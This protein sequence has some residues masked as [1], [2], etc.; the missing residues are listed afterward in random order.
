MVYT[1]AVI[2]GSLITCVYLMHWDLTAGTLHL[3][4]WDNMFLGCWCRLSAHKHSVVWMTAFRAALQE[5]LKWTQP[6]TNQVDVLQGGEWKHTISVNFDAWQ[7]IVSQTLLQRKTFV[8]VIYKLFK[9]KT[10]IYT[11]FKLFSIL[12]LEQRLSFSQIFLSYIMIK[13][14]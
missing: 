7:I 9:L 6:A 12:F 5:L 4:L 11:T 8:F 1:A 10:T 13:H 3:Y 2:P 14:Y